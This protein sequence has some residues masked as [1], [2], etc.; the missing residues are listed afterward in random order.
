MARKPE[1]I[2]TAVAGSPYQP[3]DRVHVVRV[4][5]AEDSAYL[6]ACGTVT[7]LEYACGCGQSY[8]ADPL[9]GVTFGS[10]PAWEFWPEEVEIIP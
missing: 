8:P 5:D 9:I 2:Y 4:Q 1:P 7:H 3:G 10:L 6:G